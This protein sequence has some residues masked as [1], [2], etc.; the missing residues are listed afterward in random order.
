MR[1]A[2]FCLVVGAGI[3]SCAPAPAPTASGSTLKTYRHSMDQAPTTLDP[4][5]GSNVYANFVIV[6]AY[7]TLY[8]YK[9]LARPYELKPNLAVDFPTV[10]DD[11]LVHTIQL[12]RGVRFVDDPSFPDGRGR[13]V[14]AEDLI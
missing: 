7:D 6:N 3:I 14:V 9:Y 4:V 8:A 1:T 13:E 12:K 5:Q 11:G 2:L 10:S